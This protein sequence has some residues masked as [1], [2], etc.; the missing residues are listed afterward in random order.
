M[1]AKH[2]W[3]CR[4]ASLPNRPFYDS[5]AA[6]VLQFLLRRWK[7][8]GW[9]SSTSNQKFIIWRRGVALALLVVNGFAFLS[10]ICGIS[11]HILIGKSRI[12]K[13]PSIFQICSNLIRLVS[14]NGCWLPQDEE[15]L[16]GSSAGEWWA[17]R[18]AGA[19][20]KTGGAGPRVR[21]CGWRNCFSRGLA[22]VSSPMLCLYHM[23]QK[24]ISL[25]ES[26]DS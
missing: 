7:N 23:L 6:A 14:G 17:P 9:K 8:F 12:S 25:K 10:Y 3:L 1:E 16:R 24:P 19:K 13:C 11:L 4:T 2:T 18:T 5:L 22:P 21:S 26:S 20:N 15:K